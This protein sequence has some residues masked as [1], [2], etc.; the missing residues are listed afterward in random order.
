MCF[1][2]STFSTSRADSKGFCS[3]IQSRNAAITASTHDGRL[4]FQQNAAGL[5]LQEQAP[6]AFSTHKL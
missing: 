4:D 6:D 2:K 1:S 3:D 5:L